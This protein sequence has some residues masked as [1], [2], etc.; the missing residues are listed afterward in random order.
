MRIFPSYKHNFDQ[1]AFSRGSGSNIA[2][3]MNFF[4]GYGDGVI[5]DGNGNGTGTV[6][7]KSNLVYPHY[8]IQYWTL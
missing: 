6:R 2:S 5:N 4:S 7:Q 3:F 1:Q 8:L